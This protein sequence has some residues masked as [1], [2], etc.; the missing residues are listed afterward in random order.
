MLKGLEIAA[1]IQ[2]AKPKGTETGRS[3]ERIADK[4]SS[5]LGWQP[6]ASRRPP[7]GRIA[8]A[9]TRHLSVSLMQSEIAAR[10]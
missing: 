7:S 4:L 8:A 3:E 6:R 1:E 2:D 10:T 5:R 9:L